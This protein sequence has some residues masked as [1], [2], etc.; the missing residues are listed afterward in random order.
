MT[1]KVPVAVFAGFLAGI[2]SCILA[3]QWA[4][5]LPPKQASDLARAV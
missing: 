3:V 5:K 4:G 2:W 1:S